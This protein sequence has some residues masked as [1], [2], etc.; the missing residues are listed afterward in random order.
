ME[1]VAVCPFNAINDDDSIPH[2]GDDCRLCGLC[3]KKCPVSAILMTDN[4]QKKD[5]NLNEWKGILVYGEFSNG[6]LHPVTLELL[7]KA[8]ELALIS[9]EPVYAVLIGSG[10]KNA[11]ESLAQY[12]A[13]KILYYDDERFKVFRGDI[14]TNALSHAINKLKPGSVLIGATPL[15]RS[16]APKT[17]VRFRTG[18]TADCTVLNMKQDGSLVQIRPAFGGNI[19][20]E[21]LTGHSRPQFATVR[22]KIMNPAEKSDKSCEVYACVL[23]QESFKSNIRVID[24][25][26]KEVSPDITDAERIIVAGKG[27]K[28]ADDMALINHLADALNAQVAGTRPL[29]ECGWIN[30]NRQIGLSGRTVKPKLIITCGVSGSVQ[31]AAGMK[32]SD[33]I[34]AINNDPDAPIFNIAD[35]AIKGDLYD[36]I[37]KIIEAVKKL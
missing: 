19:M 1:C 28:T 22:Y 15:G 6:K 24:V 21:I 26:D 4:S 12:P 13:S 25:V 30:P 7:G 11:A 17:A 8:N 14:Y 23:P 37:P 32:S 18:L 36:V 33:L 35:Y 27:V 20:A 2:I 10:C 9:S 5:I 31:F 3:V 29:I 34:V 16:L